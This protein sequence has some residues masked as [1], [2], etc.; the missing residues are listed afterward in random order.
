M[1]ASKELT[2]KIT[3]QD[4]AQRAN[5]S[6][7]SVSRVVHNYPGIKPG[8]RSR[9]EHA[10][11][12]LKYSPAPRK[13]RLKPIYR[14]I[15]FILTNRDLHTPFH[16]KVLQAIENECTR[17]GDLL[18]FRTFRYAPETVPEDLQV[19]QW[20]PV[21]SNSNDSLADGAI[22]TGLTYPNFLQALQQ[23]EIPFVVL[24]NNYSGSDLAGD[25]VFIDLHQGGY[26]ATRYL[27]GLGHKN[28]LFVGDISFNW[29]SSIH[30]GYLKA[31]NEN[32]LK[33]LAQ[34][35]SLSDSFYSD[36]YLSVGMAF[37]QSSE[38]TAVFA[39]YDEVA[40][41]ALKALNDRSLNVPRDVSLIGFDDEDYAAFTVPPLTTVRVDVEALG[42]E[43]ITQLY[44][45]LREPSTKFSLT[46]LPTTLVKRGSCRPLSGLSNSF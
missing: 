10:I 27:I 37:E 7:S 15:Y 4:V 5:V 20:D 41:G 9:V 34:T 1:K 36:G 45:K 28:I 14:V 38:I 24:G 17:R 11:A 18:L 40:L 8:L 13:R 29:F 46:N 43:L 6:I 12:E 32:G 25:A 3:V 44:K 22:L 30:N 21:F 42:R 2:K 19:P 35:K 31:L 39:C 26:D 16:S 33:P 23:R